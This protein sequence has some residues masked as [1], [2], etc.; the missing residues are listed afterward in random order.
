MKL[1]QRASQRVVAA[2]LSQPVGHRPDKPDYMF[3]SCRDVWANEF[4]GRR[5]DVSMAT[6]EQYLHNLHRVKSSRES[7]Y[8]F[9][10][11]RDGPL[12]K[13]PAVRRLSDP[14]RRLSSVRLGGDDRRNL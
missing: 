1:T 11:A 6:I 10:E 14:Y 8:R 4:L 7:S 2:I 12:R 13:R 3:E 9:L 5:R